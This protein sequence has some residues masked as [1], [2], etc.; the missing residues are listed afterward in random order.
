MVW[1]TMEDP[2]LGV[3]EAC[4][5]IGGFDL[6]AFAMGGVVVRRRSAATNHSNRPVATMAETAAAAEATQITS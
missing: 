5:L 6:P 3:C 2:S 4:S 1:V